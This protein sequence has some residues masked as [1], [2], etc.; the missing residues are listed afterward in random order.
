MTSHPFEKNRRNEG[1]DFTLKKTRNDF[2][3]T[4]DLLAEDSKSKN[5]AT[6]I[7]KSRS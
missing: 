5:L 3:K 2:N 6:N 4:T 1:F 7:R